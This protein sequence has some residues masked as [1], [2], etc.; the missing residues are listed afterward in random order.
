[1]TGISLA[2]T[3]G[4]TTFNIPL[5]ELD[6]GE[7]EML[8]EELV[9]RLKYTMGDTVSHSLLSKI[10]GEV[11]ELLGD[12]EVAESILR[13]AKEALEYAKNVNKPV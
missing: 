8:Q 4:D 12:R 13:G 11:E 7:L 5:T 10:L 2:F 1:M 6:K 3:Q 9:T